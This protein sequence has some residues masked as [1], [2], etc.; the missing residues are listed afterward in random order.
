MLCDLALL[1]VRH[2]LEYPLKHCPEVLLCGISA[3]HTH[4]SVVEREAFQTLLPIYLVNNPNTAVV[5]HRIW[6][7][8][9]RLLLSALV[10]WY[11]QVNHCQSYTVQAHASNVQTLWH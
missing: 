10:D 3:I 9:Q 1:Q 6:A 7:T 4:W 5:L 2:I 8:N 11:N